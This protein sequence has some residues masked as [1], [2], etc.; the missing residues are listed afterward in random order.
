MCLCGEKDSKQI[1]S[2]FL[3]FPPLGKKE[4]LIQQACSARLG[5]CADP[6]TAALS[7]KDQK[8]GRAGCAVAGETGEGAS[9]EAGCQRS[10]S[11]QGQNQQQSSAR[12]KNACG[13]RGRSR[14]GRR[15]GPI[16]A[17]PGHPAPAA[18]ADGGK[19]SAPA[20]GGRSDAANMLGD[21]SFAPCCGLLRFPK[22]TY[23]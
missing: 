19:A 20:P 21:G 3:F 13:D 9:R 12:Q 18:W 2:S 22:M 17:R 23:D 10:S 16:P 7:V 4:A 6:R 5:L 15:R 11:D 14:F 8:D 1:I